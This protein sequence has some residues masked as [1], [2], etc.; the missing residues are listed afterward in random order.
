[1]KNPHQQCYMSRKLM[2][3]LPRKE[4]LMAWTINFSFRCKFCGKLGGYIELL[5]PHCHCF[6]WEILLT[7]DFLDI[8]AYSHPWYSTRNDRVWS[9][10]FRRA[11]DLQF[12]VHILRSQGPATRSVGRH[13]ALGNR[14]GFRSQ[15]TGKRPIYRWVDEPSLLIW[16][17]SHWWEIQEPSSLLDRTLDWG[18]ACRRSVW[19]CGVCRSDCRWNWGLIAENFGLLW[20]RRRFFLI[21]F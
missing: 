4:K 12:G 3:K 8:A 6:H 14:V 16:V 21:S 7:W 20:T 2:L 18:R 9:I 19:Q 5:N 1:M 17:R 11:D 15:C 10:R 13:W